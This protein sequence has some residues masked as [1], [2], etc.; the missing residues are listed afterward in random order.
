MGFT[1][2]GVRQDFRW[3]EPGTFLMGSPLDEPERRD[4][5]TPHE[6]TLTKG[7]WLADTTVTQ[8]L[9]EAVMGESPSRF[10]GANRPVESITWHDAQTFIDKMNS[11]KAALRLCL[12]TEAQWEYA[13]R[14][15]TTTPFFFGDQISA[16][17]VNFNGTAPYNEGRESEFRAQ[18]VEVG[19]LPPNEWGLYEMHEAKRK[20]TAEIEMPEGLSAA[21]KTEV[22]RYVNHARKPDTYVLR[23]QGE[24][25]ALLP[26]QVVVQTSQ[27]DEWGKNVS[28]GANLLT[29]HLNDTHIFHTHHES[30]GR[31]RDVMLDLAVPG[32]HAFRFPATGRHEF[33]IGRERFV[34]EVKAAQQ[35]KEP[36]MR[37]VTA[38]S[39][40]LW[41]ESRSGGEYYWHPPEWHP[42]SGIMRGIWYPDN[43][44]DRETVP[45]AER[46]GRDAYGVYADT[47]I[48][49]GMTQRFR[50]IEPT[51]FRMG[52]P[53]GE[54][55]R[56]DDE[57]EHEVILTQGYWLADTA[58]TQALWQ[59]VMVENPCEF[60]D[61][62]NPVENVTWEDIDQFLL[63]LN[64]LHPELRLRLP[65]EAEWE[66]ACRAGTNGAFNFDD[67]LSLDKVNYRGTWD[68]YEKLGEGALQQTAAVKCYPPNSWGLYEM[69]GNIWEWC[70][71]WYGDYAVGPPV[72][73]PQ[74]AQSGSRRVLRGGSW[75][76]IGRYCRSA[77]RNQDGPAYL[78]LFDDSYG[79]RLALGFELPV[80]SGASQQPLGTPAPARGG[81]KRGMDG[82]SAVKAQPTRSSARKKQ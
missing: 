18:T 77:Y 75:I 27:T 8:A 15:G 35:L 33:Q 25:L 21:E 38:G 70:Q 31:Q 48:A 72:V 13:C 81:H 63:S 41:A 44:I 12:P 49:G 51:S 80:R 58:C 17:W 65:T 79:F 59:A 78:A 32:K 71:D 10:K 66:N 11:L 53:A 54:A 45:W 3:I 5:E 64:Q 56:S 4:D 29:L 73:D 7:F 26:E 50:W 39:G 61:E 69:H 74:G 67:V 62:N 76:G 46:V 24:A 28:M 82:E 34:V 23:Q 36:W 37:R 14:A 20:G 52:S 57:T 60:K 6:V 19:S 55:G 47:A 30:K 9:W 2:K 68:D 16:E 1:Y 40:G 22:L 42:G 43:S